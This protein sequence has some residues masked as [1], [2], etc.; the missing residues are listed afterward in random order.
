MTRPARVLLLIG[1]LLALAGCS[2]PVPRTVSVRADSTAVPAVLVVAAGL[3]AVSPGLTV[4]V[5]TAGTADVYVLDAARF[6]GLDTDGPAVAL[7]RSGLV[8]VGPPGT[9]P[10]PTLASA[11]AAARTI[12]IAEGDA[13]G[14]LA[15]TALEASGAWDGV[16]ARLVRFGSTQAALD[17]VASRSVDLAFALASDALGSTPYAVVYRLTDDE[18]PPAVLAGAL[19]RGA[20]PEARALLDSLAAPTAYRAWAAAGFRPPR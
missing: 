6:T 7:V 18:A 4:D 9:V 17:S 15:R 19:R 13:S 20:P 12:A 14:R 5:D 1:G 2:D 3:E 16:A 11:L 8:V 10:A